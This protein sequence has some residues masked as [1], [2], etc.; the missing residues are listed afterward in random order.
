LH[1]VKILTASQVLGMI[2]VYSDWWDG[3]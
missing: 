3:P 2:P 1:T